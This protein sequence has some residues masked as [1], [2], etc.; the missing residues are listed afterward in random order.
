MR[1]P[2]TDWRG[3]AAAVERS[4]RQC[5]CF[6]PTVRIDG[7]LRYLD[8]GL[9]H[10]NYA[11]EVVADEPLPP[12]T[13]SFVLRRI[14]RNALDGL[15]APA[16]LQ[17]EAQVLRALE[18]L[19]PEFIAP[20]FVCPVDDAD[21]DSR[22]FVETALRGLPLDAMKD[23]G[24]Q[25]R[26]AIEAIAR[27][28]AGIH[29]LPVANFG[30]L[31]NHADA[32]A[33]V[34]AGI[35]SL[36]EHFIVHDKD[37]A[38]AVAWIEEHRPAKRDAVMLH[39]D[40]LP[41]NLLLIPGSHRLAVLD[42]EYAMIGD[43]A[44]DLSIVTRGKRKLLGIGR[45]V[46]RLVEAYRATGGAA[47]EPTD[48]IAWELQLALGWLYEAMEKARAGDSSGQPPAFYRDQLRAIL[49]RAGG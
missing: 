12:D 29:R 32:D 45:G 23:G 49:R 17:C 13:G 1:R 46:Q 47:I 27:T 35:A 7:R 5:G 8:A 34:R 3:L 38:T 16:R 43:A 44:Y 30:F 6:P 26:N 20:K 42:W 10:E 28:A 40:L 4:L 39:G 41:Q 33:H 21:G 14:R 31:P 37:A 25:S 15:A 22:A 36:D 18:T 24:T 19:Q 2:W 11:F 48:V 9:N